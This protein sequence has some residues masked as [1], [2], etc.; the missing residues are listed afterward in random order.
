[1]MTRKRRFISTLVMSFCL[2]LAACGGGVTKQEMGVIMDLAGKQRMFT[3]K[4]TKEILLIAKGINVAENKKKLRQTAIRFNRTLI[5]L[6]DGDSE[7]GLVKVENP[8]IVQQLNKVADLWREFRNNVDAVLRGN[9]SIAVLK[10][11]AQQN[12]PLLKEMNKAVNMYERR[13]HSTLEQWMAVTINLAGKQRMLTQ[14]MTKELLLV[15]IGIEPVKNRAELKKTVSLFE[16]TL[17][18]LLEGDAEL[19]LPGAKDSRIREQLMRVKK[20]WNE[21]KPILTKSKLSQADLMTA[22]QLNIP[23]LEEMDEVVQM[24]KGHSSQ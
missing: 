3:Q 5:G 20:R 2:S 7:L 15:T 21:Y 1:M 14:K 12:L 19:G 11:T 23:L 8:H 24:Y 17:A 13:S 18:G 9:T 6:F 10:K 4:M 16:R 22:A